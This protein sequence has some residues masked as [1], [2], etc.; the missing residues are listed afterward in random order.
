MRLT[1]ES[2]KTSQTTLFGMKNAAISNFFVSGIKKNFNTANEI[3][4]STQ[5]SSNIVKNN[6]SDILWDP[7]NRPSS[8]LQSSKKIQKT[9]KNENTPSRTAL[10]DI[11]N[12]TI[13]TPSSIKS[14]KSFAE[15]EVKK[16][17]NYVTLTYYNTS[18]T[19]KHDFCCFHDQDL[20]V[21]P[22]FADKT[23]TYTCDNDCI[24][25]DEQVKGAIKILF[26]SLQETARLH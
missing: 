5:I 25:D 8:L 1:T 12:R 21:P 19:E 20:K 14:S 11:T 7:E 13:S 24:T 16:T 22:K 3:K 6:L 10:R 4:S 17:K 26:K 9:N 23:I 18:S 2:R 15:D